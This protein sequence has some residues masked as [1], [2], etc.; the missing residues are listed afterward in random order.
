MS[1]LDYFKGK[2]NKSASVAKERLQIIVAHE[3]G[4]REQPDYLPQLQQELLEV[5]R[6]YVQI[7]DDMVQVEVDRNESCSVLELNVTLPER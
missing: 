5:I 6:K 7:S 1:F 3:R 4:Q 2:K